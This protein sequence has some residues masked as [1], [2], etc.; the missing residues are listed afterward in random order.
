M[1]FGRGDDPVEFTQRLREA[2]RQLGQRTAQ[3]P[4]DRRQS[5]ITISMTVPVPP[6]PTI[7]GHQS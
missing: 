7:A 1:W 4:V 5:G 6:Q 3:A 2:V